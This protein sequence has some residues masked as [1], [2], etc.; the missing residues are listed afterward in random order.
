MI[1]HSSYNR[2]SQSEEL[3]GK[4]PLYL[5]SNSTDAR[6]MRIQDPLQRGW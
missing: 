5:Q 3:R 6:G 1:H 2:S 4:R